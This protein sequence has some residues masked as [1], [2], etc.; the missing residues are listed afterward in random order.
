[1][2]YQ[3]IKDN[4]INPKVLLVRTKDRFLKTFGFFFF[5]ATLL[6]LPAII[7]VVA[8]QT[9]TPN[10]KTVL[11]Q[12]LS[13]DL[14][15]PCE[16]NQTLQC[17]GSEP[18]LIT[19]GNVLIVFDANN[20]Y[21][22]TDGN[23][24]ILLQQDRV[25]AFANRLLIASSSYIANSTDLIQWP[26]AW[27][28]ITFNVRDESFWITLFDGLDELL[29]NYASLWKTSFIISILL[30]SVF[31]FLI[32]IFLDSVILRFVLRSG[33]TFKSIVKIMI[34]AMTL[35]VLI[36]LLLNLFQV[37]VTPGLQLL[38]QL[39]PIL[40]SVIAIRVPKEPTIDV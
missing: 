30:S 32:D 18:F 21:Q 15:I 27:P 7:D 23:L 31:V 5:F 22:Q 17:E 36:L 35:Y 6:A 4:I 12:T 24:V 9:L 19:Q 8:F 29:V 10:D 16:I 25:Q 13:G 34:H 2:M 33:Q 38:L 40:Y 20:Q 26:S 39:Q 28:Q 1:M 11:R 3:T 37:Q 14:N